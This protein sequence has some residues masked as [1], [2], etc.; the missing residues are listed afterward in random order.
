MTATRQREQLSAADVLASVEALA[1]VIRARAPEVETNR[2]VSRDLLDELIA[3][4]CLRLLLPASH[5]G[6]E[7]DLPT[8]MRVFEELARADASVGWIVALGASAWRDITG[9]PRPSFDAL[10][11]DGPDTLVAGVFNP[12]GVL[13][14]AA[15][16]YRVDGRWSFASGCEHAD[17][18]YGNCIHEGAPP[19]GLRIAVFHRDDVVIEDTWDSLGM[20]GTGSHHF[21]AEGVIVPRERTC[22]TLEGESCIETPLLRIPTPAQFALEIAAVALGTARGAWDDVVA[23]SEGKVPLLAHAPLADDTTFHQEL[24]TSDTRVEAAR[25]LIHREA[26]QLWQDALDGAVPTDERRARVR[27]AAAWATQQAAAAVASAHRSAG[28]AGVYESGT[29]PRRLRDINTITQHFL[30]K[31]GTMATAGALLAGRAIDVPVF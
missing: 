23:L 10:Y 30:V 1:P 2:R 16:G 9:I 12:S 15:G 11:A 28:S 20:R 13:R 21:R 18:I 6:I 14:D 27:A 22:P 31:P 26:D 7:S 17:W 24:A 29:L 8:A 3:A 19:P 25:A 4:G 5:G